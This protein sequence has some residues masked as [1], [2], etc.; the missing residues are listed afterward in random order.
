[1]FFEGQRQREKKL[2]SAI[3]AQHAVE[4]VRKFDR[5]TGIAAMGGR[6]MEWAPKTTVWSA[7][8]MRW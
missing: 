6:A 8:T 4:L 7:A 3:D 2:I 5:F 1:M